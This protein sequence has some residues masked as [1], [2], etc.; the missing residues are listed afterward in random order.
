[1]PVT[2]LELETRACY[3]LC[4]AFLEALC[5]VWDWTGK[6]DCKEELC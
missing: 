5:F 1:M 3:T 4:R 2:A 6:I